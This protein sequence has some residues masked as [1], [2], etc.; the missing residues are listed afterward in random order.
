M[1]NDHWDMAESWA[2]N[3]RMVKNTPYADQLYVVQKK[4]LG[5]FLDAT[6][7]VSNKEYYFDCLGNNLVSRERDNPAF[8]FKQMLFYGGKDLVHVKLLFSS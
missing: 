5:R 3:V 1:I 6:K 2:G 4:W 7:M 8:K